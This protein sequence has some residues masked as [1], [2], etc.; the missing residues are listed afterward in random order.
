M[1]AGK[2]FQVT[3]Q[4]EKHWLIVHRS[5]HGES[6]SLTHY[7]SSKLLATIDTLTVAACMG[8]KVDAAKLTFQKLIEKHGESRLRS[9]LA[10]A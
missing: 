1:V 9:V 7:K 2:K 6:F 10:G 3:V 5:L 8:D 4:G